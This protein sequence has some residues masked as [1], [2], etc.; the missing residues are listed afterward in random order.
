MF[1]SAHL[2]RVCPGYFIDQFPI[3]RMRLNHFLFFEYYHNLVRILSPNEACMT[4]V[5]KLGRLAHDDVFICLKL[6]HSDLPPCVRD[7]ESITVDVESDV[8]RLI[9]LVFVLQIYQGQQTILLCKD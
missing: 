5:V 8:Y 1:E 7:Q 3:Q 4:D 2:H 9:R 6:K